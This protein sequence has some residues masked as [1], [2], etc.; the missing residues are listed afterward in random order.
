MIVFDPASFKDPAGRVFH[1]GDAVY[2][3]LS[4]PACALIADRLVVDGEI[5]PASS[6][7]LDSSLVGQRVFRQ[8]RIPFVS[9][10]YE[11][12]DAMLRAA[13]LTTL[14]V[15][16][17]ALEAG[18]ILKDGNA[19][20]I[21]FDGATPLFV[22]VPSIEPYVDGQIWA[23][24]GQF[25][26][27]FVAPLLLAAYRG[28][29][30]RPLLRGTLGEI[31]LPLAAG[32]FSRRDYLRAGVIKDIVLPARL[33]RTFGQ[34]QTAVKQEAEA[35]RIPKALLA[36]N[37]ARLT[38]VIEDLSLRRS[39]SEWSGYESEC[40][41]SQQDRAEK[42]AFVARVLDSSTL[43]TVV[44]LGCNVGAYSRL[45]ASQGAR[46]IALDLDPHAI[47]QL[48][49][50]IQPETAVSPV[51][52]D[53]LNPTPSMG[54]ALEER[55]SL[56]DRIGADAFLALALIHHLRITGGVPLAAIV[57]R[58]FAIAPE[59]VIEW[60]DKSD[61][62]VQRMLSL[63]PDVY[64]DYSWSL[65]E[66]ILRERGEIIATHTLDTGRRKLCHVRAA[67]RQR[68]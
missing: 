1:H 43:G 22:D 14:R 35:Q 62:Q 58:L 51:V 64:D 38:K 33:E 45:A 56:F 53:L 48:F 47:D 21:V 26:R 37:V 25:C 39:T 3:T 66:S 23:G 44:D 16:A 63:R 67:V 34:S 65:F 54:W 15:M 29:D 18:F 40:L 27:S 11:W 61:A 68:S 52:G 13:A 36:A 9:Y 24:Y 5:V 6:A 50:A 31:P 42:T 30:V 57:D 60:V 55:R 12:S 49:E 46:V 32:L 4:T 41:Y 2:R 10:S 28:V 59:G 20:N 8:R 17:R 19:F 7:G